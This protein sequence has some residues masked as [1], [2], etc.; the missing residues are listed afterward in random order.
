MAETFRKCGVPLRAADNRRIPGWDQVRYR[1]EGDQGE[2]GPPM[3]LVAQNCVHLIRTLP[4]MQHDEIRPEDL[5]SDMEDHAV[6]E[7][8]YACMSRFRPRDATSKGSGKPKYG[9]FD[10][11]IAG[12]K[13]QKSQYRMK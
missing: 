8:R 7:L 11:L 1:L 2:N 12:D 9:T 10:W 4:E 3:I 6:D 13:K 5:D